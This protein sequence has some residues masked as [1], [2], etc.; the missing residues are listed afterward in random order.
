MKKTVPL[1]L[2]IIFFCYSCS[3]YNTTNKSF[4]TINKVIEINEFNQSYLLKTLSKNNDTILIISNAINNDYGDDISKQKK[5]VLNHSYE[6]RL[7]KPTRISVNSM[8]QLGYFIKIKSDTIWKS[9]TIK[10]LPYFGLNTKG[11][12]IKE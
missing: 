4:R 5:I 6:F 7:M 12:Y 9:K 8:E 1:C 11:L 3:T 10:N 2:V